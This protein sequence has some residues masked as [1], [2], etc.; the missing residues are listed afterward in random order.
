M[1][2]KKSISEFRS[3]VIEN[4]INIEW[5]INSIISTHYLGKPILPFMLDVLNDEYFSLGL[6]RRILVKILIDIKCENEDVINRLNR[7]NSIRNYFAHCSTKII[8][9]EG[10]E[11]TPDPKKRGKSIDFKLLY[12]EFMENEKKVIDFLIEILEKKMGIPFLKEY[13]FEK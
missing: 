3:E 1:I 7:M 11:F 10:K 13:K 2:D 5:V 4:F 6:K 12:E 8:T 9:K